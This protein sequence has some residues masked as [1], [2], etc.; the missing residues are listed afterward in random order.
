MT[1]SNDVRVAIEHHELDRHLAE[2]PH[3][4]GTGG[5][6]H[7][8]AA[9]CDA[10]WELQA[11]ARAALLGGRDIPAFDTP[12]HEEANG[13]GRVVVRARY[14]SAHVHD[15]RQAQ[16]DGDGGHHVTGRDAHADREDEKEGPDY[17][18]DVAIH[19]SL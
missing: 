6:V 2:Q 10:R 13:D 14:V 9:R 15:S 12:R 11:Q 1:A 5:L 16:S 19:S 18:C 17:L 8:R 7:R 3:Q 4:S